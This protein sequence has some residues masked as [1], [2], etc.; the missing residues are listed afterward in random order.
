MAEQQTCGM[1]LAENSP[2]PGALAKVV[3]KIA[4]R[5]NAAAKQM[6]GYRDLPS[7]R[8]DKSVMGNEELRY[9]F[10][11]LVEREQDLLELLMDKIDR[12]RKM[13]GGLAETGSDGKR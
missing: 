11:A 1:G 6:A 2:F 13:L 10:K 7:G 4:D 12:E 5:L 8:H 9:A 3:E